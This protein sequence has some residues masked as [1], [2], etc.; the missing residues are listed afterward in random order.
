VSLSERTAPSDV[1]WEE[2]DICFTSF[3]GEIAAEQMQRIVAE[4]QRVASGRRY[5]FYL[6]DVARVDKF[7]ASAR[8]F[9]KTEVVAPAFG[10][11]VF[12]ASWHFQAVANMLVRAINLL[13]KINDNPVRF[14]KT[15]AEARAWLSE[16][17]AWV[18]SRDMAP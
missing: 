5:V 16:R 3:V 2:P 4:Q 17:R 12:G 18:K 11:A 1:Q 14:F 6:A 10:T 8:T 7:S 13:Q 9:S 15:E